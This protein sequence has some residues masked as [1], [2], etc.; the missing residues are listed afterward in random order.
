MLCNDQHAC[1]CIYFFKRVYV[2]L[3]LGSI[4][5]CSINAALTPLYSVVSLSV[6]LLVT[7]VVCTNTDEPIEIPLAEW[8]AWG[9][10]NHG[11]PDPS[12]GREMGILGAIGPTWTICVILSRQDKTMRS[13][14]VD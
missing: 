3:L 11:G 7:S 13:C 9:P 12:R 2:V 6:Y 5:T 8:T 1:C 10:R 14:P 4:A